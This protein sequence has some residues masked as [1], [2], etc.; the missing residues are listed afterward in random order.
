MN[1]T[2]YIFLITL[3]TTVKVM[4]NIRLIV[5]CFLGGFIIS[6]SNTSVD[7]EVLR[8]L[9]PLWFWYYLFFLVLYCFLRTQPKY[10]TYV[11]K[12]HYS[13]QQLEYSN[14]EYTPSIRYSSFWAS[15]TWIRIVASIQYSLPRKS[16][17]L[18]IPNRCQYPQNGFLWAHRILNTCYY[19]YSVFDAP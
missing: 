7:V 5:E 11:R 19:S 10:A 8:L 2:V 1:W 16:P 9:F 15:N 17:F 4:L 6:K 14:I 3:S 12:G 13:K 18:R